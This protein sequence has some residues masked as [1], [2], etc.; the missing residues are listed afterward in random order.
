MIDENRGGVTFSVALKT[1]QAIWLNAAK[2]PINATMRRYFA[3][4]LITGSSFENT[5]AS[6][7][8]IRAIARQKITATPRL[9][10]I[11]APQVLRMLFFSFAPQYCEISA[12]EPDEIPK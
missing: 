11:A 10:T 8:G 2:I 1:V 7:S 3:A 9:K 6:C 5:L 12:A 4:S